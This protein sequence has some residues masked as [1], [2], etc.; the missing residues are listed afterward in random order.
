M[1]SARLLLLVAA[2]TLLTVFGFWYGASAPG[3]L[4]AACLPAVLILPGAWTGQKLSLGLGGFLA[5][6]Y[7]G[8]GITELTANPAAGR[9]AL[10]ELIAAL[11]LLAACVQLLRLRR[12]PDAGR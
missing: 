11:L 5:L 4:L 1:K 3:A 7:L 2:A 10:L 6:F 8:H 9:F 12:Q